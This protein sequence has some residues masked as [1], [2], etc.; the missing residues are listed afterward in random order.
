MAHV[1]DGNSHRFSEWTDS[2]IAHPKS[3]AVRAAQG[4]CERVQHYTVYVIMVAADIMASGR[5]QAASSY[6]ADWKGT[7]V[8]YEYNYTP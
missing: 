7:M 8:F 5:C 1:T 6:H 3:L 2:P 4:Y